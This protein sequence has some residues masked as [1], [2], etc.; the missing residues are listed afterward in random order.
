MRTPENKVRLP[1]NAGK[2]QSHTAD[3]FLTAGQDDLLALVQ[4]LRF[5]SFER[6]VVAGL[7]FPLNLLMIQV[8]LTTKRRGAIDLILDL[9][10]L[11]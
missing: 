6:K 9:W 5:L 1:F 8:T 7:Y 3:H 4:R 2:V 10:S 11:N